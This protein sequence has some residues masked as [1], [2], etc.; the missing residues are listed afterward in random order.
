MQEHTVEIG[1]TLKAAFGDKDS[2]ATL[3]VPIVKST[4]DDS[5]NIMP[6]QMKRIECCQSPTPSAATYLL[7][8]IA[9]G[10][11][12]DLP[13]SVKQHFQQ[14]LKKFIPKTEG[15][16]ANIRQET[17]Q[18]HETLSSFQA[19]Y[20]GLKNSV[21]AYLNEVEQY[22]K[23][24]AQLK[25]R[26]PTE[27]VLNKRVALIDKLGEARAS[28]EKAGAQFDE[29]TTAIAQAH[30]RRKLLEADLERAKANELELQDKLVETEASLKKAKDG[31][32]LLEKEV[33]DL[34]AASQVTAE[35][36]AQVEAAKQQV[37]ELLGAQV[38]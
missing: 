6:S 33:A 15:E 14:Q 31:V 22:L 32:S 9:S 24:K 23:L 19:D 12:N 26:T 16:L 10:V 25:D 3:T 30:K 2:E 35:E 34:D 4:E 13:L 37:Q 1:D 36:T 38:A 29:T 21:E 28:V 8:R 5:I 17:E 11:F 20:L 18:I 7:G 27:D